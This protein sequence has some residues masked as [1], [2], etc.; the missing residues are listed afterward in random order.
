VSAF[1][2]RGIA[3]KEDGMLTTFGLMDNLP[4]ILFISVVGGVFALWIVMATLHAIV[5]RTSLE[6]SRREIAAYVAEGSITPDDAAK[7]LAAQPE[8]MG[9]A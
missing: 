8:N 9:D 1:W 7:L 2:L 5:K 3:S 6:K 4:G